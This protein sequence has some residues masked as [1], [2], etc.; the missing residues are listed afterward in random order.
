M[1]NVCTPAPD[2]QKDIAAVLVRIPDAPRWATDFEVARG[3]T[4]GEQVPL[5]NWVRIRRDIVPGGPFTVAQYSLSVDSDG[6]I[7]ETLM[8]RAREGTDLVQ[9]VLEDEVTSGTPA[10]VL[11]SE[12]PVTHV[13][14][15][16]MG[17]PSRTLAR[18]PNADQSVYQPLFDRASQ[19][20]SRYRKLLNARTTAGAELARLGVANA[21]AGG[22]EASK[23]AQASKH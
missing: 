23:G 21:T 4:K 22:R 2:E 14:L 18:C 7:V 10:A 17:K 19:V 15:E 20:L 13:R 8:L 3:R 16:M 12:T 11:A 5:S 1:L 6:A 9:V